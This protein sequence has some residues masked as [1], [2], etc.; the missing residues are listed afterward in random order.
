MGGTVQHR[1]GLSPSLSP[2]LL[3]DD[4]EADLPERSDL[5]SLRHE[6]RHMG[7]ADHERRKALRTERSLEEVLVVWRGMAVALVARDIVRM[8][9]DKYDGNQTE[10]SRTLGMSRTT[11]WRILRE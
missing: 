2:E 1:I 10:A 7:L 5:V 3:A 4:L 11:V 6:V 8:V 9:V